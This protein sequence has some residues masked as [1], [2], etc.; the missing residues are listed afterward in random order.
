M[1]LFNKNHKFFL[2]FFTFIFFFT[3]TTFVNANFRYISFPTIGNSNYISFNKIFNDHVMGVC[4]GCGGQYREH[5]NEI[6]AA[7][8]H[9]TKNKKLKVR[10]D[11]TYENLRKM[12]NSRTTLIYNYLKSNRSNYPKTLTKKLN[13]LK[14]LILFVY[15][16]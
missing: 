8:R 1:K 15:L 6:V 4:P 2:Y 7:L 13:Q 11:D 5:Y 10:W 16:K 3:S 14:S 9:L 12:S